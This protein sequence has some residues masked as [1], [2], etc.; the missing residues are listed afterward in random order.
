MDKI[1]FKNASPQLIPLY[2]VILAGGE[3]KRFKS[4]IPKVLAKIE[5]RAV[6]D[7]ILDLVRS[8]N[9]YQIIVITGYKREMVENAIIDDKVIFVYQKEQLGTGNAVSLAMPL[10]PDKANVLVLYGDMPLLRATTLKRLIQIKQEN[11]AAFASILI[12]KIQEKLPYGRIIRDEK[13]KIMK[14]VENADCKDGELTAI[15]EVNA[16]FYCFDAK[17]LKEILP[18]LKPENKQREYYL[19]DVIKLA[20]E[21]GYEII[22]LLVEDLDEIQGITAPEDVRKCE[23]I[24]KRRRN[25]A[26]DMP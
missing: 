3:G 22:D 26:Q 17:T 6:I 10:I 19:T 2:A 8:V 11:P 25:C 1:N 14:I 15:K 18:E 4:E 16:G 9:P 5:G 21:K 24:L 23:E 13:N 7:Y 20:Y 12:A